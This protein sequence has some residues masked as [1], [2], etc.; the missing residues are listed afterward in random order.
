MGECPLDRD[1]VVGTDRICV[2]GRFAVAPDP[3]ALDERREL[4]A[5]SGARTGNDFTDRVTVDVAAP[6]AGGDPNRSEQ[7]QPCHARS[8]RIATSQEIRLWERSPT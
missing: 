2:E 7:T 8:L 1:F 3:A 5:P 4:G 6:G